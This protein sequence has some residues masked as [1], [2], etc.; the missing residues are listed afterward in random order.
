[1]ADLTYHSAFF[2]SY[3]VHTPQTTFRV[4]AKVSIDCQPSRGLID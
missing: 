2:E 3:R 4:N 1:M